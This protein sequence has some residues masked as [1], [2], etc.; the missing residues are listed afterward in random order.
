MIYCVYSKW[1]EIVSGYMV[2]FSIIQ[3][4]SSEVMTTEELQ[5][6]DLIFLAKILIYMLQVCIYK[7][8]FW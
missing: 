3:K 7:Y 4:W 1:S 5:L 6:H 2:V 8:C